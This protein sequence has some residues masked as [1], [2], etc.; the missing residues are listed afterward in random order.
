MPGMGG[1]K[2][3]PTQHLA[4]IHG[5]PGPRQLQM[6]GLQP[7]ANHVRGSVAGNPAPFY[8]TPSF[9]N[10]IEQLGKLARFIFPSP[11]PLI[12]LCRPRF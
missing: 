8:P 5:L 9:Q 6:P 1:V 2:A 7:G 3:Q 11:A 10:H 12:E 4:P